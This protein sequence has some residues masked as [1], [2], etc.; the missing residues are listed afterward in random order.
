MSEHSLDRRRT[1]LLKDSSYTESQIVTLI[2][3]SLL[4]KASIGHRPQ[5]VILCDTPNDNTII[6][7]SQGFSERLFF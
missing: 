2:A 4:S 3:A 1:R 5:G 6:R 7:K